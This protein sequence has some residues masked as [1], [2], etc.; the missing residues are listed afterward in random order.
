MKNNGTAIGFVLPLV[1][2]LIACASPLGGSPSKEVLKISK[3]AV[4]FKLPNLGGLNG[5]F[6]YQ[7]YLLLYV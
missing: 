7:S 6:F 3:L 1:S 4:E 2:C 5:T